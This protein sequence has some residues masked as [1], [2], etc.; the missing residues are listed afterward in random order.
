MSTRRDSLRWSAG[1]G[2]GK[3]WYMGWQARWRRPTAPRGDGGRRG[4][5]TRCTG[6]ASSRPS[7]LDR[8]MGNLNT[9]G[10][11]PV[12]RRHERQ[13]LSRDSTRAVVLHVGT[14]ELNIQTVRR[15]L[16]AAFGCDSDELISPGTRAKPSRRRSSTPGTR[17]RS[18]R[19]E[20]EPLDADM[21]TSGP[22]ATV[23]S[24]RQSRSPYRGLSG[25][26]RVTAP[27]CDHP[28]TKV[29]HFCHITNLT[30]Q[31]FP[32]KDIC[33]AGRAR[34]IRT[35]VDGAHAFAH[36]PFTLADLECDM[37]GTSL[38]KWLLAPVGIGFLYVRN[39]D[40]GGMAPHSRQREAD[41][42][43]S[44]VRGD[45][46]R[47]RR[48]H[49]TPSPRRSSFTRRLARNER[50]RA[51]DSSKIG[52]RAASSTIHRRACSPAS[53]LLKRARSG[54]CRSRARIRSRSPTSSGRRAAS[55]SPRSST[56][57]SRGCGSH[58]TCTRRSMKWMALRMR[59]TS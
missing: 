55:S 49:T 34:G 30:G 43:H 18:C 56:P 48:R 23:S 2:G 10:A 26:P 7:T 19:Y 25:R 58:P 5:R 4:G 3:R 46:A 6:T 37:Y 33:R 17:P 54:T 51:C 39:A 31:I 20:D 47:T 8:T 1:V 52:G 9:G 41:R 13:A 53:T 50:P 38:H 28:A 44:Q 32:V 36:F 22:A 15:R 24:S 35:I 40:P 12:P 11:C 29:I 16:A 59:S 45:L 21:W 57:N 42:E 27:G 14:L